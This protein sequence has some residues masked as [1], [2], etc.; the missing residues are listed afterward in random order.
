MFSL[1]LPN[2]L[3]KGDIFVW[4]VSR[5]LPDNCK[6]SQHSKNTSFNAESRYLYFVIKHIHIYVYA[7]LLV[8]L[9]MRSMVMIMV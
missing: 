1:V 9:M 3:Q 8:I 2:L 5:L 6:S 4:K 7:I